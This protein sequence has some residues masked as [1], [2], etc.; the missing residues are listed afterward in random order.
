MRYGCV[1]KEDGHVNNGEFYTSREHNYVGE[2]KSFPAEIYRKTAEENSLGRESADCGKEVTVLQEKKA[3]A[4]R[5]A[6]SSAKT[7]VDKVF[8]S[9]KGIATTAAVS[10]SAVVV[11][12]TVMTNTMS[13]DLISLDVGSDYVE[14]EVEI[15]DMEGEDCYVII[16][17][18]GKTD[19]QIPIQENGTHKGRVEGLMPEWEYTLSVVSRDLVLGD[20]TH[21]EC[22]FQTEKHTEYLPDPPNSYPGIYELPDIDAATV[23]WSADELIL[24]IVFENI[25]E[26]YYY[27][28][29]VTDQ[30]ENPLQQIRGSDSG[31][32]TINISGTNSYYGFTFAIYGVGTSEE[33]L[34]V[35]HDLGIH[36]I[37]RPTVDIT[38]ISLAGEN[39]VRIDYTCANTDGITL[40]MGYTDVYEDILLTAAEISAG[41]TVISIPETATTF[42]VTPIITAYGYTLMRETIEK[43]FTNNL[44]VEPV[45]NLN[46]GNMSIIF[47]MK[48]VTNGATYVHVESSVADPAT[49]D[50]SFWDGELYLSYTERT[51]MSFTLYLTDDMGTKLSNEISLTVDTTEPESIPTYTM[52]YKNPGDIGITYNDDGTIN[53]YIKTDF[54]C[55]DESYYCE[56][57]LGSY[58][59]KTRDKIAVIRNIP[60]DSYPVEYAVGFD[61]DGWMHTVYTVTPSGMINELYLSAD[62]AL[63]GN[64]MSIVVGSYHNLD[65]NSIKAISSDGQEISIT[66]SDFVTDEYGNLSATVTFD[67]APEYVTLQL[68]TSSSSTGMEMIDDYDGSLYTYYETVI[69]PI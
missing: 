21:F 46:D 59:F 30:D 17:S 66:E 36:D 43:E 42:T 23:D 11:T 60:N 34:I 49:G 55:E 69:Q 56:I 51:Q 61:R 28:L 29:T 57:K 58:R 25:D 24:P 54:E 3:G 50:Y 10:V 48:A 53:V 5:T 7:L 15:S 62:C 37:G 33:C 18:P 14:Y 20:I 22:K 44:E 68:M 52:N 6:G 41:Y 19:Q 4:K 12:T 2:N 8:K 39:R 13:A 63:V 27:M 45:V 40:R 67:N 65:L 31:D 47:R 16:G 26:K 64:S 35:S 9:L 1:R 38:G 32:A